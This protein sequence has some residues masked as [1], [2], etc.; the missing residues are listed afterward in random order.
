MHTIPDD[1]DFS[2]YMDEPPAEH[3]VVPASSL[4]DSVIDHFFKPSDAPKI[5]MGWRKTHGDFEFR[6]AEVSLWA[7]INGH[8]KSQVVGQVSLDLM[9]QHQRVCIASL[10]MAPPKVMARMARQ[11]GGR[12]DVTVPFLKAFHRW[13]DNR[14]WIYDHVGS[15][16]PRTILA[17]IR[18]AV[19]KF[20]VQH[21]VVD[22]LA[23][24]IA[25]EDD[26]NGQKAFVNSLCTI[27][28]DTGVHV[29]L[30]LHVK[31]GDSEHRMPGKFDIK[32]SGAIA[33]LVDNIFIVWRNKAKEDEIR[34]GNH[35]NVDA[36]DCIVNL[37][38]QRHGETEGS[39]GLWFDPNS[40]QYLESRLDR[41]KVYR[42]DPGLTAA[43]VEF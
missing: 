24:V 32:G 19:E 20:G 23:K 22:N 39:Y 10:E 41:P 8:G 11:A 34:K 38:K 3:R 37:E 43:Q 17:V 29:H 1:I 36:P 30:V 26:Y 9:D 12:L 5:Q 6:P 31:K 7:G 14:L 25:Q 4:L 21:F 15:S 40:M 42:I 18:Y 28:K 13:T 33:D 35:E 16:D 2:A 27:A